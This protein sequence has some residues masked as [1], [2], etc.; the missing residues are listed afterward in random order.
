MLFQK[1]SHKLIAAFLA[2]SIVIG[3]VIY[4]S[5]SLAVYAGL[6][7]VAKSL[8]ANHLDELA[9]RMGKLYETKGSWDAVLKDELWIKYIFPAAEDEE[10]R[11]AMWQW[12]QGQPPIY[13]KPRL[14]DAQGHILSE[15]MPGPLPPMSAITVNGKI[16]G[17]MGFPPGPHLR[18]QVQIAFDEKSKI[19]ILISICAALTIAL[20][21]ALWM[22]RGFLKPIHHIS[23]RVHGLASGKFDQHVDVHSRDELGTLANDINF[24]AAALQ[25][26]QEARKRWIADIAHE[27]RTPLTVL[28]AEVESAQYGI[29]GSSEDMLVSMEEEIGQLGTLINDLRTLAQS[30]IGELSFQREHIIALDCFKG[31]AEKARGAL[32]M[33]GL[34]L[35]IQFNID[36]KATLFADRN[37][38][39]Q[40]L[41]NL[42]QNSCRYT[43]QGGVVRLTLKREKDWLLMTWEDSAPG[44][45][46]DSLSRLFERLY[47]VEGSR[48]RA[49]GGSGLGLA[50]CRNIVEAQQGT[51]EA[52]H[53]N[54]GGLAI[55]CRLPLQLR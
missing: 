31:F 45:P 50:I 47:R 6:D 23:T 25:Q 10:L 22:A 14:I 27:L 8:H 11:Q 12:Q 16:V 36:T 26:S 40:L 39:K 37:R 43:D 13:P 35:E 29:Q 24:L 19:V 30:D 41:D 38:L 1:I 20:L 48:N 34:N 46:D 52:T 51:I 3:L 21:M 2:V 15:G 55:R 54:L 32:A 5:G 18:Q 53:S 49:S 4:I 7:N 17:Y 42:L 33:H 44:V 28:S 9:R